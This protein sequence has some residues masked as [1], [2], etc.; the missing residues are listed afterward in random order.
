M[1]DLIEEFGKN[2]TDLVEDLNRQMTDGT[3]EMMG[4]MTSL[5]EEKLKAAEP[6]PASQQSTDVLTYISELNEELARA[7]KREM[8]RQM[9]E[10]EKVF[11]R[12]LE[13]FAFNDAK[14]STLPKIPK[15]GGKSS[16]GSTSGSLDDE[17]TRR[18]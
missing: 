14:L 5:L 15:T 13:D 8:E 4:N 16:L 10:F 12:P 1:T 6:S 17:E 11:V 2:V 7:Q 18:R 9:M 3:K